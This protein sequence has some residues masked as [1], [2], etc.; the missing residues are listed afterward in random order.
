MID[1]PKEQVNLRPIRQRIAGLINDAAV[2]GRILECLVCGSTLAP[3]ECELWDYKRE[4]QKD[5]VSLAEAVLQIVSFY[6]TY[7]GYLI[8]GVEEVTH[9]REFIPTAITK[10]SLDVQQLRQQLVN[11]TGDGEIDITYA[12]VA[13]AVGD[14]ACLFGVLHIPKRRRDRVPAFFGKDGPE[15]RP[16]KP[17]FH[18]N[19]VYM[20]VQDKCVQA[21][22]KDDYQLLFGERLN[23]FL[24]DTEA[25]EY[26]RPERSIVVEHNLPDRSF[27]CPR[28]IGRDQIIED[29]WKWLAD[30]LAGARVLAGEGG[31]GKTSIAYEFAEEVCRTRPY[32]V[33]KIMWLTAKTKQFIGELD[34]F[35]RVPQTDFYDLASLLE[36]MCRELALTES[37]IEGASVPMLKKLLKGALER[38]RCLIVIDDVDSTDQ[39]QQKL[40]LEAAMQFPGSGT[41]FLVTTRMNLTYSSSMS[42]T[43]PG[44]DKD[45]YAE[46]VGELIDR[47]GCGKVTAKQVDQMHGVTDGSPLFTE[48]VLRLSRGGM[49]VAD[50]MKQWRGQLGEEARKAALQREVESLSLESRRVLLA[51]CFMSEASLTELRQATGYEDPRMQMCLDELKSLFLI[52]AKPFI[53]REARF[54]VSHNTAS[55]VLQNKEVLVADP[56]LLESI[57]SKIRRGR[58]STAGKRMNLRPVGSAIT[59]AVALLK[60]ERHDDAIATIESALNDH[61]DHPDLVFTHGR[62]LLQKYEV[63]KDERD[64]DMARKKFSKAYTHGQRKESLFQL[65]HKS[66]MLAHHSSGAVEVA[67]HALE[68]ESSVKGEWLERRADAYVGM[69]KSYE[70]V[71]D[72]STALDSMKK[73][74]VDI[75]KAIELSNKV[76]KAPLYEKLFCVNDEVWRLAVR[77]SE[78]TWIS[79]PRQSYGSRRLEVSMDQRNIAEFST[80]LGDLRPVNFNRQF[81]AIVDACSAVSESERLD[82]KQI[83]LLEMMLSKTEKVMSKFKRQ[84]NRSEMSS[85]QERQRDMARSI[86]VLAGY[87]CPSAK[88]PAS[89]G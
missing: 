88:S 68:N 19:S 85:Y 17:V 1:T 2:D 27:I 79:T 29:L 7:G 25:L 28:F 56:K 53:K 77:V 12:E 35:R 18:E 73:A 20:R 70:R 34:E 67:R 15:K 30:E 66:E 83:R 47:F 48:S 44:L 43:V 52:S 80:R 9:D 41:R 62:C 55:L 23:P 72:Y 78:G 13:H 60:D 22:T 26:V 63:T 40:I 14:T 58:L 51:C 65:W 89:E 54:A 4:I 86:A 10:G 33:E 71:M 74:A 42:I 84:V 50:A 8:Y 69:S 45:D 49:T 82:S 24:W 64:L 11:F 57:V 36:A 21:R 31:K 75:S 37:E 38:F 59:Q 32:G 81:S 3:K 16:G 5:R 39:E 76:G 6:N 61:K 87:V 46:Y